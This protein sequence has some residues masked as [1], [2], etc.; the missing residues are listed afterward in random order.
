MLDGF[1]NVKYLPQEANTIQFLKGVLSYHRL[2]MT[3]V[4]WSIIAGPV[5][6]HSKLLLICITSMPKFSFV[7]IIH[8]AKFTY[9]W[10]PLSC[11]YIAIVELM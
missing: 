8:Y 4:S 1:G 2:H 6:F 10:S 11:H 7:S 5:S 3:Y 9:N